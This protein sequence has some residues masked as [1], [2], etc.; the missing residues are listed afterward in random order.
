MPALFFEKLDTG[1][2]GAFF[3]IAYTHNPDPFAK[4]RVIRESLKMI[5]RRGYCHTTFSERQGAALEEVPLLPTFPPASQ[6]CSSALYEGYLTGS[7]PLCL[8]FWSEF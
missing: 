1:G 3:E 5:K 4:S 6:R 2:V 8:P 7:A